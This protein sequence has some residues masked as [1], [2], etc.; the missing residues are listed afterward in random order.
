MWAIV[1]IKRLDAGK[2]RLAEVLDNYARRALCRAMAEDVVATLAAT[3][4]L[5]EILV[6]TSD[7]EAKD[8]AARYGAQVLDDSQCRDLNTA[9]DAGIA[10]A[11]S[12]G[13]EAAMVVHAD[14]PLATTDEFELVLAAH[15]ATPNHEPHVTLVP[16]RDE[17]GTN[18]L[19]TSPP[20]ALSLC[21][22]ADSY[23]K[24]L[25]DAEARGIPARTLKLPGIG[26]DIDTRADLEALVLTPGECLAQQTLRDIG[27]AR[28][29]R[30]SKY[31]AQK[32][33]TA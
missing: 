21:Y 6:V 16:A 1:P 17:G 14:I 27:V 23:S 5:D 20:G 10:H 25:N 18:C 26:L 12:S 3:E 4:G 2:Q 7:S 19:A 15:R 11:K 28:R 24:H 22:G 31:R 8:L 32:T 13:A 29:L 9:V 30:S 33:L